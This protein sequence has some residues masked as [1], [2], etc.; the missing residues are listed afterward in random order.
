MVWE[1]ITEAQ[2]LTELR[3]AESEL[4]LEAAKLWQLIRISPVK[5]PLHPQGDLGDGFWVVAIV[6]QECIWYKDI[7]RGFDISRFSAL[8]AIGE[9]SANQFDLAHCLHQYRGR[10]RN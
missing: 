8:G 1:P 7:E 5:W 2:L 9:Y 4:D 6:G 3:A 10:L